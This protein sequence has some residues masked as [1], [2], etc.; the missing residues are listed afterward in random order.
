MRNDRIEGRG[1]GTTPEKALK[2]ANDTGSLVLYTKSRGVAADIVRGGMQMLFGKSLASSQFAQY[3][4]GNPNT[5]YNFHS[6]MTLT[7]LGSARMLQAQGAEV[8]AHFNLTSAFYSEA[9]AQSVFN[10][11]GA[12]VNFVPPNIADSA[13]MFSNI[14][15]PV[16]APIY[17]AAGILT[18]EHFHAYET[19]K[20]YE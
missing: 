15:N 9:T 17:G 1:V 5:I 10:S 12:S 7:A 11:I 4:T 8:S 16:V 19:Y 13:G 3:M 6:E 20:H 14:F 2:V 18:G